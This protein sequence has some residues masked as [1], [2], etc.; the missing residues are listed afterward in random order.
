MEMQSKKIKTELEK[1]IKNKESKVFLKSNIEYIANACSKFI[2][3]SAVY[4]EVLEIRCLN[5]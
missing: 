1:A 3:E 5:E 4:T 2:T